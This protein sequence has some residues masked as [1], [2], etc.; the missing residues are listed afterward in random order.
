[1]MLGRVA[2]A[3]QS[4]NMGS[5]SFSEIPFRWRYIGRDHCFAVFDLT[6]VCDLK[7]P[8]TLRAFVSARVKKHVQSFHA[9]NLSI[10]IIFKT[11]S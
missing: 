8:S 6:M 9:I 2:I 10:Y 1:M 5:R 3:S 7:P 11:L 4:K